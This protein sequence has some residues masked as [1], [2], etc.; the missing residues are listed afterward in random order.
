[1]SKVVDYAKLRL[2]GYGPREA[3]RRAG[4]SGGKASKEA[5]ETAR[6]AQ[7]TSVDNAAVESGELEQEIA[8]LAFQLKQKR[9]KKRA[10]EA[11]KRVCRD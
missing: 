10:V 1:M 3:G 7:E 4:Y 6:V 5:R 8:R 11:I 2:E 9:R